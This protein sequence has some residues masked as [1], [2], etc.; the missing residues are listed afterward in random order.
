MSDIED[1][2]RKPAAVPINDGDAHGDLVSTENVGENPVLMTTQP[3]PPMVVDEEAPPPA[4]T[5]MMMAGE[6]DEEDD[7]INDNDDIM[8]TKPPPPTDNNDNNII[9]QEEAPMP[10]QSHID[11]DDDDMEAK[12]QA[13]IAANDNETKIQNKLKQEVA[14][15]QHRTMSDQFEDEIPTKTTTTSDNKAQQKSA[16]NEQKEEEREQDADVAEFNE[17]GKWGTVSK[18]ER[19]AVM[20]IVAII[21]IV[22][23]VVGVVVGLSRSDDNDDNKTTTITPPPRS[24]PPPT[25][26]PPVPTASPTLRE[27]FQQSLLNQLIIAIDDNDQAFTLRNSLSFSLNDYETVWS[28]YTPTDTIPTNPQELAMSWLFFS[29]DDEPQLG[30]YVDDDND[31]TKLLERWTI[32]SLYFQLNGNNWTTKTNWLNPKIDHCEWHGIV[33]NI[34]GQVTNLEWNNNNLSTEGSPVPLE[35]ALMQNLQSI[36]LRQN[37]LQLEIPNGR[38]F[39]SLPNI[40]ILN[41]QYNEFFGTVPTDLLESGSLQTLLIQGN[42]FIGTFPDEYCPQVGQ[43]VSPLSRFV[44]DC[45]SNGGTVTCPAG[46]CDPFNC[47]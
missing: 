31:V 20:A 5:T 45:K 44:M 17:T 46:C 18:G 11:D 47:E 22:A 4:A 15:Q 28:S 8:D 1:D 43:A 16:K 30:N 27:P 26:S 38:I 29:G 41:L 13:K 19:I 39:G 34:L 37:A 40:I 25:T 32:V 23:I 42:N 14:S 12:I 2:D 10:P 21:V 6:E 3:P 36:N 33:C 9:K 7:Y 24:T 35:F